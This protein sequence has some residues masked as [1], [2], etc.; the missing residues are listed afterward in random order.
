MWFRVTLFR[1]TIVII[2]NGCCRGA[3]VLW[4][5]S[6]TTSRL[7]TT[8]SSITANFAQKLALVFVVIA[9]RSK[10]IFVIYITFR[11][12]CTAGA[13]LPHHPCPIATE[14]PNE[15]GSNGSSLGG[16]WG[17]WRGFGKAAVARGSAT[18]SEEFLPKKSS[19]I[20]RKTPIYEW[21]WIFVASYT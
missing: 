6:T 11:D 15:N 21:V 16:A 3:L 20:I 12:A 5:L 10:N 4:G 7:T 18:T 8:T 13:H 1:S 17:R 9:R 19:I 14:N 2:G